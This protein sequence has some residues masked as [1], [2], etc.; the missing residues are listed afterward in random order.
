MAAHHAVTENMLRCISGKVVEDGDF[1]LL[2]LWAKELAE[3]SIYAD[4]TWVAFAGD[5]IPALQRVGDRLAELDTDA[6]LLTHADLR[7]TARIRVVLDVLQQGFQR[8]REVLAGTA[9]ATG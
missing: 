5:A 8:S 4:F 3:E 1:I 9:P 2:D 6:W 7:D